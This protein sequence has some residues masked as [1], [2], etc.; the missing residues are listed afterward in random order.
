MA[1]WPDVP[2]VYGWL[3]LD[4]RGRWLLKG[5]AITN[6]AVIGFIGRNYERDER[7]RWFFQNG[8]QRVYVRLQ[9]TP[10]VYRVAHG[11]D[12]ALQLEAQTGRRTRVCSSSWIDEQGGI[13]VE[14]DIGVGVVHDRDLHIL[15]SAIVDADGKRINDADL[16]SRVQRVQQGSNA[17]DLY[18][19]GL[20][21][22]LA[23]RAVLST[24]VPEKFG[25]DARPS[26]EAKMASD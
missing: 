4:R 23:I 13:I 3:E 7:G 26:E 2:A 16:E 6:P 18:L 8:P 25:F 15:L 10:F 21:T 12:G 22:P 11:T 17:E 9:Y 5:E 14:T 24:N 19:C 20:R 1:K